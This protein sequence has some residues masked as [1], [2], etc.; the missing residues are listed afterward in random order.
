M[1]SDVRKPPTG[2]VLKLHKQ[3]VRGSCGWCGE[4]VAEKTEVHGW[5]KF[6]HSDCSTE[7]G[8]IE[9]PN[10]ARDAVFVRD[11]GIC[12]D[13]GEDWSNAARLV[14]E[15]YVSAWR[16]HH[17]DDDNS[18]IGPDG[19][20]RVQ[21]H[22]YDGF[23]YVSLKAISLWHVDHKIPLWKVQHMP[24][25][26]RI[27]YFKLTNLVTRCEPCHIVK[28]RRETAERHKFDDQAELFEA[29]K[30][31]KAKRAWGSRPMGKRP[32]GTGNGFPPRG[33][34]PMRRRT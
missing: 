30:P 9:Q 24:A 31:E 17:F 33:S 1:A 2:A 28:S 26:Q 25:L 23:A 11:L 6:W 21:I 19:K 10:L 15:F 22:K 20:R 18:T 34:T 7:M 16:E 13:C 12:I 5:L 14:P 29:A 4:P 8:I 3:G 27:E 32:P